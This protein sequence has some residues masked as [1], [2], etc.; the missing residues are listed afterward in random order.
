MNVLIVDDSVVFRASI[1]R[2]LEGEKDIQIVG[3]ARNGKIAI[4]KLKTLKVDLITLDIE[5]PVM[6][7]IETLKHI[8]KDNKKIAVLM[9][10]SLTQFGAKKTIEALGLGADD[11]LSKTADGAGID[12]NTEMI[13]RELVPKILQFVPRFVFEAEAVPLKTKPTRP[14][15]IQR[16]TTDILKHTR[17]NI[18]CI[19][20]STGGPEAL[21]KIFSSLRNDNGIPIVVTQ[22]MPPVF[23][24]QLAKM[25]DRLSSMNIKEAENDEPIL[26][27]N[28]YI[29]PGDYHMTV[30]KNK[31]SYFIRLNQEEKVN[32]VRPAVDVLFSSIAKVFGQKSMAI[33]LTGMG[34]DGLQGAKE[35]K[36]NSVPI[37]IQ[38]KESSVVWGM[39]GAIHKEGIQKLVLPLNKMAG[40]IDK[41]VSSQ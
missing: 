16:D 17:P 6:D 36:V 27:N 25:L 21:R 3:V 12:E 35:L 20:S 26:T 31:D 11:F 7:G 19:G 23:T 8:R 18:I 32:H 29:A 22:H 15:K 28:C 5:M 10:S 33:I 39:P 38:D 14:A 1:S 30:D 4:E 2:A 24:E 40:E 9:F 34:E 41:I 37:I 13:K